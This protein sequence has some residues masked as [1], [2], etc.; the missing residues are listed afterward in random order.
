[1]QPTGRTGAEFRAGASL[2]TCAE[3]RKLVRARAGGLQLMR[4]ALGGNIRCHRMSQ[5]TALAGLLVVIA[6]GCAPST[7]SGGRPVF[8]ESA[9]LDRLIEALD[10]VQGEFRDVAD[11][12]YVFDIT[13]AFSRKSPRTIRWRSPSSWN[14]WAEPTWCVRPLIML[15]AFGW[16]P[17]VTW[18]LP[19]QT[20]FRSASQRRSGSPIL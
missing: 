9:R 3:E 13:V 15:A 16:E 1:M 18:R 8:D 19:I 2:P 5:G 6:L 17:C 12:T 11:L 14:A 7:T 10:T 4:S 20:T